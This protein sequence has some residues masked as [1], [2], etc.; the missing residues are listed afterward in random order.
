MPLQSKPNLPY[1]ALGMFGSQTGE[2]LCSER[3][4]VVKLYF[5]LL[6]AVFLATSFAR[7]DT[8]CVSTA[9]EL[10]AALTITASNGQDDAV[11]VVQ[12]LYEGNFI[13]ATATE[14]FD[15]GIFGGFLPGCGSQVVNP[16]NTLLDGLGAGTVLA[17]STDQ[18]VNFEMEGLTLQ[19]GVATSGKGGGLFASTHGDLTLTNNIFSSSSADGGTGGGAF[20]ENADTVT[21]TSNNFSDNES[22]FG[23]GGAFIEDT[24]TVSV[25]DN[26]FTGNMNLTTLQGGGGARVSA[27]TVTLMNNTI[28]NNGRSNGA[29]MS[30]VGSLVTATNNIF[31][32]NDGDGLSLGGTVVVANNT[33]S[34]N[35]V[36]VFA[37]G[38]VT[39]TNNV[40]RD[41]LN[42]GVVFSGDMLSLT[43]NTITGNSS[44][45]NGGGLI[46][47]LRDDTDQAD[48]YNNIIWGNS[49]AQGSD[50]FI[51]NDRNGNFIP[52]PVNLFHNDFDHSAAG[53]FIRL[54]F[55]IDPS[56]LDNIDPLFVN[57]PGGD[58][59]L[60]ALSPVINV[61]DNNAPALPATDKEGAPRIIGGVVDLGA[62]EFLNPALFPELVVTSLSGPMS[63][64]IGG[65]VT[66]SAVVENAGGD[67]AS[68]P[69]RLGFYW[70]TDAVITTGDVFSGS[71]CD[72][73]DL[74]AGGMDSCDLLVAV[75]PSL[76]P[77]HHFLG[78]IVDDLEEITESLETN[79]SLVADTGE[80]NLVGTCVLG[81]DLSHASGTLTMDFELGTLDPPRWDVWLISAFGFN[82]LW[83]T[84]LPPVDPIVSFPVEFPF[85]SIGN[86][87]IVTTL[88]TAENGLAFDVGVLDTGGI[89]ATLEELQDLINQERDPSR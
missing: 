74:T 41:N 70:S 29:G 18:T 12:G 14:A 81:L 67:V 15:L 8:F 89:G 52:S 6:F 71:F 34:N 24:D 61:G 47:R 58:F 38:T 76:P 11:Q 4:G 46:I 3:T 82:Q 21:L 39:L 32:G 49:A 79:N 1:S 55:P 26:T 25:V 60:Q 50:L 53:T 44:I 31:T 20:L 73:A 68:G 83:T 57:A 65:Q 17:L 7:A 80:V 28:S 56:N 87:I 22:G 84:P 9:A 30:I 2:G 69:F 63:G 86:I 10:Q 35:G 72:F 23:G 19:N 43:N 51:E 27:V 36:G 59:H 48:I 78:A 40:I 85:P 64:L 62:F 16:S 75:P 54:P 13:Y 77:G 5:R 33:F 88:T 45:G 42:T 66:A 37:G